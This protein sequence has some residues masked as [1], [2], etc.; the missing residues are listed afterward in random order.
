MWSIVFISSA[1]RMPPVARYVTAAGG[2]L[3]QQ[4]SIDLRDACDG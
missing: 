1:I 4:V 2:G 3:E